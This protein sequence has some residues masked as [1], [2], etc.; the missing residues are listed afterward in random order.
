MFHV[1]FLKL[2]MWKA[3]VVIFKFIKKWDDTTNGVTQFNASHQYTIFKYICISHYF[4]HT[5]TVFHWTI[6]TIINVTGSLWTWRLLIILLDNIAKIIFV[7]L[8]LHIPLRINLFKWNS[9]INN[10]VHVIVLL[11]TAKIGFQNVTLI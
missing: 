3:K 8:S 11:Y 4:L 9:W 7:H 1:F 6:N 2:S 10:F 5:C